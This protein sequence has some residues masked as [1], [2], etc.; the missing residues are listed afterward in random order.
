MQHVQQAIAAG[1]LTP[2]NDEAPI[3]GREWGLKGDATQQRNS[4]EAGQVPQSVEEIDNPF[5]RLV[6]QFREHG[7]GL[8]P[9]GGDALLCSSPFG[10]CCT[11]PDLRTAKLYL[12]Q[13]GG[14]A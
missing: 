13:I 12:Q 3:P 1:H 8:Y 10:M 7:L 9:L 11:L 4:N 6:R 2:I 14:A 5:N